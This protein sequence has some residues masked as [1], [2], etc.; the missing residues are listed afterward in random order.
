[1]LVLGSVNVNLLFS[2]GYDVKQ[3]LSLLVNLINYRGCPLHLLSEWQLSFLTVG[4]LTKSQ[5]TSG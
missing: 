4:Q 3:I 2:M 1:M 5:E